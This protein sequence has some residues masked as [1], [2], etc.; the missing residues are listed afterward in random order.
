MGLAGILDLLVCPHCR[1][2]LT[3]LDRSIRCP[4]GHSFDV[5]RQGYVNLLAGSGL[6]ANADSAAMVQARDR[7]LEA[8]H[9]D[10]LTERIADLAVDALADN[11]TSGTG[12]GV[13]VLEPGAGTG[14]YLARLLDRL[15]TARGIAADLSPAACK[16]SARRHDRIGAV[17]ADTWSGLPVRDA[18]LDLIMVVFAPQN[19]AEFARMLRPGGLLLVAAAAPQ[20]LAGLREPLG[21]LEVRPGKRD[22]LTETLAEWFSPVA[23][24]TVTDEL[25]L[26][27]QDLYDLVAMGPNAHHQSPDLRR[28]IDAL[29]TPLP[30]SCAVELSLFR[31]R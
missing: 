30:V 26:E 8:G 3:L 25:R 16:R 13:S 17:V 2:P 9:Y 6:R 4:A 7:F 10:R 28:R 19:A 23:A 5:A 22:R 14:H 31:R 12:A 27:A 18:G 11:S 1:Q 29:R 24:E 20:H 15:P 21:L